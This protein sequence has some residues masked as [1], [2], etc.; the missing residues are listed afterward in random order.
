M[1][2]RK[3]LRGGKMKNRCMKENEKEYGMPKNSEFKKRQNRK[4]EKR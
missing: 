2:K 1:E 3:R 4:K